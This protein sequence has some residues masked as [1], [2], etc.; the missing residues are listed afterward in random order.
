M[1]CRAARGRRRRA[2]G[3]SSG[4]DISRISVKGVQNGREGARERF[5]RDHAL[6]GAP[7]PNGATFRL[8]SFVGAA[9]RSE[10]SKAPPEGCIANRNRVSRFVR[11]LAKNVKLLPSDTVECADLHVMRKIVIFLVAP[12]IP[13]RAHAS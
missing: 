5:G 8:V 11:K 13:K 1:R 9:A 7:Q 10:A 6:S 12:A 3:K 2:A 4:P